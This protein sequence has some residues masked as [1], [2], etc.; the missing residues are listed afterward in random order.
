[1]NKTFALALFAALTA[2]TTFQT[3]AQTTT[4]A[5][6]PVTTNQV[7]TVNA[8]LT[9]FV[10]TSSNNPGTV[11]TTRIDTKSLIAALN[12]LVTLRT[13]NTVSDGVTNIVTPMTNS[14][15][16]ASGRLVGQPRLLQLVGPDGQSTLAVRQTFN[17]TNV[18]DTDVSVWLNTFVEGA[19]GTPKTQYEMRTLSLNG[20]R[21]T[22]S[23]FGFATR[24]TRDVSTPLGKFTGMTTA[25]NA[26]PAGLGGVG[27][28]E[29]VFRGTF[30]ASAPTVEK[31]ALPL[32]G[33]VGLGSYVSNG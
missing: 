6:N 22:L 11:G 24:T 12:G 3:R 25:I 27:T 30:N 16:D 23:V 17:R 1:M 5:P 2:A 32:K 31:K 15:A 21:L 20:N 9:A 14:F 28:N 4:N 33:S 29:A 13:T 26:V 10:L 8:A 18:V 7:L 19:V